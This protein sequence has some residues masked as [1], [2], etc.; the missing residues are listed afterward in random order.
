MI[1]NFLPFSA[2]LILLAGA[3]VMAQEGGLGVTAAV[4]AVFPSGRFDQSVATGFG[5]LAGVELAGEGIGLTARSGY[6]QLGERHDV[7]QT[8]IPILGGLKLSTDDGAVYVVGELGAIL[9]QRESS[10]SIPAAGDGNKTNPGWGI[11]VGSSPG[12]LD[13]RFSFNVWDARHLQESM[14]VGLSFGIIL[15]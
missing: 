7:T 6:I 1:K 15:R 2:F 10:G 5:G 4:M 3:P 12:P 11:G 14:A 9:T 8:M 13:L